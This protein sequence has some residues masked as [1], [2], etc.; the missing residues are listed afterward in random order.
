MQADEPN[1]GR[2]KHALPAGEPSRGRPGPPGLS[3]L[4]VPIVFWLFVF[5][6]GT[7]LADRFLAERSGQAGTTRSA[8]VVVPHQVDPSASLPQQPGQRR[9]IEARLR[10]GRSMPS[11]IG[12]AT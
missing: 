8:P 4:I 1:R 3:T 10:E 5:G 9:D 2:D 7:W 6:A 12:Q 11:R